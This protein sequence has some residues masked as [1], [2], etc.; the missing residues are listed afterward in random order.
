MQRKREV[1]LIPFCDLP[2]DFRDIFVKLAPK[3]NQF[4]CQ[5]DGNTYHLAKQGYV[6]VNE[7]PP[8]PEVRG[9]IFSKDVFLKDYPGASILFMLGSPGE[10]HL[11]DGDFYQ[12]VQNENSQEMNIQ[13]VYP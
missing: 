11:I 13:K 8:R 5:V 6:T 2:H 10:T 4:S 1:K 3:S 9:E 7:P 12:L